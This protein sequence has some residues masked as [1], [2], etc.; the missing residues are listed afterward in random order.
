[1]TITKCYRKIT[2]KKMTNN[3]FSFQNSKYIFHSVITINTFYSK[4]EVILWIDK[5]KIIRCD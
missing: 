4:F 2:I 1:M 5:K 3:T